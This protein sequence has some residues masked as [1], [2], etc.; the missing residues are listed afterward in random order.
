MSAQ[1][2]STVLA[3]YPEPVTLRQPLWIRYADIAG[4]LGALAIG[5]KIGTGHVACPPVGLFL[6]IVSGLVIGLAVRDLRRPSSLTLTVNGFRLRE[7]RKQVTVPWN[8]VQHFREVGD[9]AFAVG[10][11]LVTPDGATSDALRFPDAFGLKGPELLSLL[12]QWHAKSLGL[13]NPRPGPT[14]GTPPHLS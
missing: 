6:A 4:A 3:S 10:F 8:Y 11:D 9:D 14:S 5:Y 13:R 7:R 1:K 2:L 12:T